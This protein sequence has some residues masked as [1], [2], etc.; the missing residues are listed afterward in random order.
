MRVMIHESYE[1]VFSCRFPALRNDF[2]QDSIYA[3]TVI[4]VKLHTIF[5]P[6][7]GHF[8]LF[9]TQMGSLFHIWI[10]LPD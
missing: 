1:M 5:Q 6:N 3:V 8:D 4:I 9:I 10:P 2:C 7:G